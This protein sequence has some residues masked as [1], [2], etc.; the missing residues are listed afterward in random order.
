MPERASTLLRR[1]ERLKDDFGGEVP[2]RRLELLRALE[3]RRLESAGQVLR[4]HEL[5]CFSRAYPDDPAVL[6]QVERMLGGFEARGDLKR[7]RAALAD[8]GMAGTAI[9]YSFFWF[10]AEWLARRWPENLTIDW[11]LFANKERL[12]ELLHLLLPYSETL[13]VDELGFSTRDWI[14]QLKGPSETDAEFLIRRFAALRSDNFVRETIYE[15]LDVPVRVAPGGDT[16]SRTKARYDGLPAVFQTGPLSRGRPDLR[17]EVERPPVAVRA[18]SPREGRRLVDLAREAMVTRSRDL[19]IFVHADKHDTRLVDCGGGLQFAC[20]GAVPERRLMLDSVYGML[21]LKSGVPM[22]YVLV[23]TIY[24]SA[25]VAYNVFETYRGGEAAY[26]YGRVLATVRHLFDVDAFTVPP[27]QLGY[28][29]DEGLKSGAWWF[30]Y[31]LG[32]RPHDPE[33]RRVM[34]AELAKMKRRP[35]HRS[36]LATLREL[37]QSNVFLYLGKRRKD[38][39]GRISLGNIGLEVTAYMAERFGADRDVGVRTCSRE[40]ARMLGVRSMSRWSRGERLWWDRWSP[41]IMTL[42]GVERWS[43][44]NK[45]ALVRVVR[46]KGGR[47]ES[48]FVGLF[49]RHRRLRAAVLRLA[50]E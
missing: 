29:N 44:S 6:S 4:L 20:F 22:G 47:R 18:V 46:A 25:E 43:A 14:A 48:D 40:A 5:L 41:L 2:V 13:T 3:R 37:V 38:V 32:F 27:Y 16:P 39:R 30:Y 33:V 7:F 45:R 28:D 23:S 42:P 19:D 11:P 50:E 26:V 17:R 24:N 9:N 49:D 36:S 35:G 15:L 12:Q 10:T 8:S 34:R 1:L 31:K 21:T